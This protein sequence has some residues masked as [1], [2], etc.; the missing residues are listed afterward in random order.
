M[1][2]IWAISLF[3]PAVIGIFVILHSNKKAKSYVLNGEYEGTENTFKSSTTLWIVFS[4]VN[5]ATWLTT[6]LFLFFA[7]L[8]Y[9]WRGPVGN[10]AGFG[11]GLLL[12]I[13]GAG[14]GVVIGLITIPERT[15]L[16]D[17]ETHTHQATALYVS[18]PTIIGLVLGLVVHFLFPARKTDTP[19]TS[20]TGGLNMRQWQTLVE[21]DPEIAAAAAKARAAGPHVEKL[22]AE[23]YLALNDKQ[24]LEA[25]LTKALEQSSGA[26]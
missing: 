23:K 19:V 21:L 8:S 16:L 26:N 7:Y 6:L 2:A 20:G 1:L 17:I 10:M 4:L 11:R 22:L 3:V 5:G 12:G 14:V 24:Y 9:T 25:A 15:Y 18:I 13:I